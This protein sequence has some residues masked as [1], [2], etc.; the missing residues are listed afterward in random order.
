MRRRN[1]A[2]GSVDTVPGD[3]GIESGRGSQRTA[4]GAAPSRR[5]A[6][7]SARQPGAKDRQFVNALARGLDVLRAFREGDGPL[8]NQDI[9]QRANLPK[10]TVSR[11]TYTLTRLG[12]LSYSERLGKYQIG[13]SVL[14]LGHSALANMAVRQ[15]ARGPMQELADHASAAVAL[16]SRDRLNMIYIENC[17]SAAT[18]TLRIDVGTRIPVATTS[19]GRAFLA[20]LPEAE[21]DY[22][23]D[24]IRRRHA[25]TW[26]AV[27]RGIEI[28]VREVAEKGFCVTVGDWQKDIYSVGVPLTPPDG[29]DLMSLNCGGPAFMV[30]RD[31]LEN[32]FGPRLVNVARD[33]RAALVGGQ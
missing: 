11:L 25:D 26:P 10:P 28:A 22:L 6:D 20:G 4:E 15:I 16:G 14:A 29:G 12:Y 21:R 27:R 5:F 24:H 31:Q 18:I 8:G 2:R 7:L 1:M 23:M 13:P 19:M 33:V 30:S 17:R 3:E 9:A 32:D